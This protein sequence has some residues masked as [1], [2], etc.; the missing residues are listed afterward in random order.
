MTSITVDC[1]FDW[2]ETSANREVLINT[3]DLVTA[4]ELGCTSVTWGNGN[5][6][7]TRIGMD[8]IRHLDLEYTIWG[9]KAD[10]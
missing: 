10:I 4:R 1:R 9:G 3:D 7:S 2:S 6:H 5:L 8:T